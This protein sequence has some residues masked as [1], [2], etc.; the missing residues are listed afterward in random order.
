MTLL[1]IGTALAGLGDENPWQLTCAAKSVEQYEQ[2]YV[3]GRR[4][5]EARSVLKPAV[6]GGAAGLVIGGTAT[7]SCGAC[8]APL[9]IAGCI[10]PPVAANSNAPI[11]EPGPWES[12]ELDYREGYLYGYQEIGKRRTTRAALLGGIAGTTV[13]VAGAYA[14][15]KVIQVAFFPDEDL[16]L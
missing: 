2:G 12:Q 9:A 5:A 15:L 13:G 1:L 8:G 10:V 3:D 4:D 11:P 6:L 7:F 14:V 16:P